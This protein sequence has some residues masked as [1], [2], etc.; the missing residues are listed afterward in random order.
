M[1]KTIQKKFCFVL[2]IMVLLMFTMS[3]SVMAEE[4]KTGIDESG[5][6]TE[7]L[8]LDADA[9]VL[10]PG[11]QVQ[12]NISG[13]PA[14]VPETSQ[15]VWKT[16]DDSVATVNE[17]GQITAIG[18]GN[19]TVEAVLD[20]YKASV[21]VIV[22][23]NEEAVNTILSDPSDLHDQAVLTVETEKTDDASLET[24]SVLNKN[25]VDLYVL[26]DSAAKRI[27]MPSNYPQTFQIQIEGKNSS[28]QWTSADDTIAY[29]DGNGIIHPGKKRVIYLEPDRTQR[30]VYQ[31]VYNKPVELT[32]YYNGQKLTITVTVNGYEPIYANQVA[33]DYLAKNITSSMTTY[34]KVDAICK[35]VATYDYKV[36]YSS[37]TSMIVYGGGD[38]WASTDTIVTMCTKLGIPAQIRYRAVNDPGAGSGHR[39]AYVSIDNKAYIAEAG[40]YEPAPR[41]YSISEITNPYQYSEKADGTVAITDYDGFSTN[42][43]LVIPKEYKGKPVTELGKSAF[44]SHGE[45]KTVTIPETVN[46]LG[47][48][49][50]YGCPSL[51]KINIPNGITEIPEYA[52]AYT[53]LNKIV[54]P[55]NVTVIGDSAFSYLDENNDSESIPVIEIPTSVT[56]IE[57][58]LSKSKVIYNGTQNQWNKISISSGNKPSDGNVFYLS[59]GI[60]LTKSTLTLNVGQSETLQCVTVCDSSVE[61]TSKAP[62]VASVD[63]NGRVTGN[64][65]G[66]VMIVAKCNGHFTFCIVTVNGGEKPTPAPTPTP[67]PIPAPTPA[68][69]PTPTPAPAPTPAPTPTPTSA[70]TPTPTPTPTV[71]AKNG[72]LYRTHVQDYGWQNYVSNGSVSGTEGQSKRLEGINIKLMNPSYSGSIRYMTHIQNKG[73]E[74]SWNYDGA[75]SGT[76]GQSLRLEAIKIELTGEMAKH[77]DVYYRVHCQNIGWMGWAK[78]GENAGSSGYGYRLEGIQ[79]ELVAK[80]QSA[81]GTTENA[82]RHPLVTYNTHVQ[83]YG[84]QEITMDGGISGTVGQAKR[85]EGIHIS[86]NDPAYAG[87][88][89]YRTHIQ[90]EGWENGWKANGMMSGTQGR[91]LRLEAIQIRLTGAMFDQYDVYY[92]VHCQNFGW[93]GWAK[94]GQSAGSAGFGYRLEGIQIVL[95][96]KGSGSPGSTTGAFI[97]K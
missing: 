75:M 15:V 31:Y 87:S 60:A 38:C 84:W 33:D 52:F 86:L 82:Y 40:Y 45:F 51:E 90:N 7:C 72:V 79:I 41:Y 27:S 68:P 14:D 56:T 26:T 77:Y 32:G 8:T 81:P 47:K 23:E 30:V 62:K 22:G 24:Q 89:Q 1:E 42:P 66:T 29:V 74:S 36:G 43:N 37:M 64:Q 76:K 46:K 21:N 67:A 93:M 55:K 3:L 63:S 2:C 54:I 49:V 10:A 65:N 48:A 91:S 17:N 44:Y 95:V 50:F 71:T 34:Q 73:W 11:N 39:N 16:M 96:Q 5:G 19:T 58:D 35:F 4:N 57:A 12:V 83:D 6:E 59:S 97:Q 61:W 25:K 9:T 94:D 92:R 80:G 69:T 78:N 18:M 53:R 13:K 70:P 85:L 28:I 88:I 20:N